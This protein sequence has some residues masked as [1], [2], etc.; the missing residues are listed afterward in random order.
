MKGLLVVN[1]YLTAE[2]YSGMNKMLL[3]A[4]D[5]V[6]IEM[7]L[8]TNAELLAEF[9]IGDKRRVEADFVLFWDKDVTL[10]RMIEEMGVRSFNSSKAIAA[11]DNKGMTHAIL[12]QKGIPMP[13][14]IVAPL[15]FARIDMTD[16]VKSAAKKLSLPMVIKE[17]YGSFGAQV[18]KADDIYDAMEIASSISP[19]QMIFQEFIA[20]SSGRDVRINIVGGEVVASMKRISQKDFRANVTLGGSMQKYDPTEDEKK[21]ALDAA[22][23][24]GLDFCGVD[25]LFGEDGPLLCEV[26]SNAHVKN[27]YDCTGVNAAEKI[28]E[29]IKEEM[30]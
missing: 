2:K 28:F 14:T 30:S 5:K 3:D 1:H 16:F 29:Y 26:N 12:S 24:L 17:S 25:L 10:C 18:Y 23:A 9:A 7:E 15:S 22:K 6:G 19:K 20:S 8:K 11:C 21:I 27:I 4:A 13:K